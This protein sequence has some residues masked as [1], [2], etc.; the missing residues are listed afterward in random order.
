MLLE[1]ILDA[2]EL[3]RIM[4]RHTKLHHHRSDAT[5]LFSRSKKKKM[6]KILA[7]AIPM[8]SEERGHEIMNGPK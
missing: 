2:V 4:H 5:F 1:I 7:I 8:L 6:K 3:W